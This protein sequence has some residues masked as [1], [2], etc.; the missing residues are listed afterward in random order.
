[1]TFQEEKKE[2]ATFEVNSKRTVK[3]AFKAVVQVGQA[4]SK[5]DQDPQVLLDAITAAVKAV[6]PPDSPNSE[7]AETIL[8]TAASAAANN[9]EDDE[10]NA[11]NLDFGK[12]AT[13]MNPMDPTTRTEFAIQAVIKAAKLQATTRNADLL[14][15]AVKAI[16]DALEREQTHEYARFIS[17]AVMA[18]VPAVEEIQRTTELVE[19]KKELDEM[20]KAAE[21]AHTWQNQTVDAKI[22]KLKN[23][24][25]GA[26]QQLDKTEAKLHQTEAKLKQTK[27]KLDEAKLELKSKKTSRWHKINLHQ[28]AQTID[29]LASAAEHG[30]GAIEDVHNI[31]SQG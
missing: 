16:V 21:A 20:K 22:E 12:L 17:A 18:A 2:D 6:E 5:T 26:T 23:E 24:L 25:N 9:D 8:T 13:E 29:H 15:S 7:R 28:Q 19:A 4:V 1:M 31:A 30:T 3:A 10:S 14:V 27:A 11:K